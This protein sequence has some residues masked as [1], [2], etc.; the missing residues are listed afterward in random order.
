MIQLYS[1]QQ[2]TET[3]IQ[4]PSAQQTIEVSIRAP[5][6]VSF[7]ILLLEAKIPFGILLGFF[8]NFPNSSL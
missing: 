5:L 3:S 8:S 2:T 1:A 4:A 7:L 6:T